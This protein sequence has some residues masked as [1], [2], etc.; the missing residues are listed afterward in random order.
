MSVFSDRSSNRRYPRQN[1]RSSRSQGRS[2]DHDDSERSF[3]VSKFSAL[4][5]EGPTID[6]EQRDQ[7]GDNTTVMTGNTS[8]HSYV[9]KSNEYYSQPPSKT[10]TKWCSRITWLGSASLLSIFAI[11]SP[12][13]MIILPYSFSYMKIDN[14]PNLECEIDCQGTLIT[15]F[16]KVTLLILA[17]AAIFWR[18][19]NSNLPRIYV[20]RTS[21]A[22]CVVFILISFWLF[23]VVRVILDKESNYKFIVSF[24]LSCLDCLLYIHYVAVLWLIIR[25]VKPEYMVTITR[26]PDGESKTFVIGRMTIQEA[27]EEIIKFYLSNFP[28]YNPHFD[29]QLREVGR[30][31]TPGPAASSGFKVYNI[32][33]NGDVGLGIPEAN[34]H[35][36]IEAAARRRNGSY[37]EM[38]HEEVEIERRIKKRKIKLICS[39]EEAFSGVRF[40]ASITQPNMKGE[41]M[42][43]HDA[44]KTVFSI[45]ARP[46]NKYLRLMRRQPQHRGGD[47]IVRYIEKCLILNLGPRTFLQRFFNPIIK[48]KNDVSKW[49]IVCSE[50]VSNGIDNDLLFV[51]KSHS[52]DIDAGVQLLCEISNLPFLNITEQSAKKNK[53]ENQKYKTGVHIV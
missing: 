11:F 4:N 46:L 28:S 16:V 48:N 17:L 21:L 41:Q 18:K 42:S 51:I 27:S 37:S 19:R 52:N 5:S 25:K 15:L 2:Y 45:I 1:I 43:T 47:D 26:D 13:V 38:L 6:V 33:G 32:D 49:S 3:L 20:A 24:S 8:E 23:F 9:I 50:C 29:K 53:L 10:P 7:W 35:A 34:A 14:S 39:T 31:K 44:A 22:M 12:I 40:A 30:F 36:I